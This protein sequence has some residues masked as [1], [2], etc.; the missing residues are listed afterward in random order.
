MLVYLSRQK[1]MFQRP[2]R[3][4]AVWCLCVCACVC[5]RLGR[6]VGE[7]RRKSHLPTTLMVAVWRMRMYIK[8]GS[9]QRISSPISRDLLQ[10]IETLKSIQRVVRCCLE[11][12]GGRR[13]MM[14][15]GKVWFA[16]RGGRRFDGAWRVEIGR[17]R[18][19]LCGGSPALILPCYLCLFLLKKRA[20]SNKVKE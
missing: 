19:R 2:S 17:E 10:K 14:A 15:G 8:E 1:Q 16:R 11:V 12:R 5:V 3:D 4:S 13:G 6:A 20:L 9:F 18:K 7:V